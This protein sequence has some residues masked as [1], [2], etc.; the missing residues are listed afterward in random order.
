MVTSLQ[1]KRLP[2]FAEVAAK[3]PD[4]ERAVA[5]ARS[6][7]GPELELSQQTLELEGAS[8]VGKRCRFVEAST[9]GTVRVCRGG[10]PDPDAGLTLPT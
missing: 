6:E 7:V 3:L 9:T 4:V 1:F 2:V 5:P 10:K 8:R